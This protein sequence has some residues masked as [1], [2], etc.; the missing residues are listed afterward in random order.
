MSHLSL[1][2]SHGQR[3]GRQI[4]S[5]VSI[6]KCT[7]VRTLTCYADVCWQEP[8]N[9]ASNP[10]ARR[11]EHGLIHYDGANTRLMPPIHC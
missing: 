3:E 2:L 11:S 4:D 5:N 6:A 9:F 1:P 7:V 8:V 10:M